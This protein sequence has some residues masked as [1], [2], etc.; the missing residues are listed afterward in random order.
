MQVETQSLVVEH[1]SSFGFQT[2]RRH[3]HKVKC[4]EYSQKHRDSGTKLASVT[5]SWERA[6]R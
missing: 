3:C 5:Y 6:W 4:S 1:N 2:A